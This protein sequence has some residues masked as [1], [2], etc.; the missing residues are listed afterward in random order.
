M[1]KP[2]SERSL[3]DRDAYVRMNFLHQA[4]HLTLGLSDCA[5]C[6]APRGGSGVDTTSNSTV[7][8]SG[9]GQASDHRQLLPS[10]LQPSLEE[11]LPNDIARPAHA[12]Q[13]LSRFYV[14]E[15]KNITKRLVLRVSVTLACAATFISAD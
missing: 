6:R 9:E 10:S 8:S 4:A 5:P 3:P 11:S 7:D 12:L 13:T 15:M 2:K 1:G 14:S